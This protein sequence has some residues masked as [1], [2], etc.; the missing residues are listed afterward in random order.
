MGGGM[1]FMCE[2]VDWCVWGRWCVY[3]W[4]GVCVCGACEGVGV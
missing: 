1:M 3:V 4:K 2:G